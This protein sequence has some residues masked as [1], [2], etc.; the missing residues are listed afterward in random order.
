MY[1]KSG[2]GM[3][4]DL[5]TALRAGP[6]FSWG[7]TSGGPPG[8]RSLSK[9]GTRADSAKDFCR[10]VGGVYHI[11]STSVPLRSHFGHRSH[12]VEHLVHEEARVV[13]VAARA[14]EPR[15]RASAVDNDAA[16]GSVERAAEGVAEGRTRWSEVSWAPV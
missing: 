8:G 4:L 13:R 14:G 9:D 2:S 7:V 10:L 15:P 12:E 6:P 11:G 5:L 1:S 16:D 3:P